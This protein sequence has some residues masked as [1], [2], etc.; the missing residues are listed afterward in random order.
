MEEL[1]TGYGLIEAPVWE[2]GR[3]LYW[4]DVLDGGVYCRSTTV[5]PHRRGIG[6]MARHVAGG[7]V[8]SGRNI[9][10]K[11]FD[12]GATV[13]LLDN[14]VTPHLTGFN[15]LTVDAA[16]RIYVGSLAFHALPPLAR[17][18]L[19]EEFRAS[20]PPAEGGEA[21]AP[22]H[23]HVI[24]LDGTA[25]TIGDGVMLTNGLAFS[26]DGTRLY[27]SDSRADLI[28]VYD[29]N[30]TD[31]SVGAWR[32]FARA[33]GGIPDGMAVAADGSVWVALAQGGAVV[34]FEPDGSERTRVP[35]PL[36]MVTSLCFGGDDL[37]DL[38]VVTGSRGGPSENC[39]TVFR[40]RVEVPGLL[41]PLARV[42]V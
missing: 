19:A 12:G 11:S 42:R 33:G 26:P 24:D 21:S 9:A 10:F 18:A 3:G 36:P 5:I 6:G 31:G 4:S 20:A 27:H 39:G 25:R 35:V 17:S 8:V 34:V 13:V 38:Y 14:V 7:L 2:P 29:V 23:L 28:R 40:A 30:A 15:D 22:G 37:R 32:V 1:A 16:G 41:R